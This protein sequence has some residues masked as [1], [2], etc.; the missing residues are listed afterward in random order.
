MS[1]AA[2]T[3]AKARGIYYSPK[4]YFSG[5]I[6]STTKNHQVFIK[7]SRHQSI[8]NTKK[9]NFNEFAKLPNKLGQ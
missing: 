6:S 8:S 2:M 9:S 5:I 7:F 1:T 4:T 3:Y